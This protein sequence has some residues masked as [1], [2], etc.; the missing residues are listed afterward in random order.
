LFLL[1]N[2]DNNYIDG[3]MFE[4]LGYA[5][6]GRRSRR[7]TNQLD[8]KAEWAKRTPDDHKQE[9]I[10]WLSYNYKITGLSIFFWKGAQIIVA[11]L[12]P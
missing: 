2:Q 9:N 7:Y 11:T 3:K 12:A 8:I 4:G 10:I 1:S 5:H 6:Q